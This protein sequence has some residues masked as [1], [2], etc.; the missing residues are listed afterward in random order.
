MSCISIC[1]ITQQTGCHLMSLPAAAVI[2]SAGQGF[3]YTGHSQS[4]KQRFV[5]DRTRTHLRLWSRT[6]LLCSYKMGAS[7]VKGSGGSVSSLEEVQKRSQE[8]KAADWPARG[9]CLLLSLL[10]RITRR[11]Q[12][13]QSKLKFV[14][15]AGGGAGG[16]KKPKTCQYCHLLVSSETSQ[17]CIDPSW[18]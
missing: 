8:Q 9:T 7:R 1:D 18:L 6:M 15:S 14:G 16:E 13:I 3:H 12:I 5:V 11:W 4:L 10:M 2:V 17:A